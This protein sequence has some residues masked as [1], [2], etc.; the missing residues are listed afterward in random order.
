M[1]FRDPEGVSVRDSEAIVRAPGMVS[2]P[3]T[4][5]VFGV[6][7]A[8]KPPQTTP[9]PVESP[10]RRW[11]KKCHQLC[12]VCYSPCCFGNQVHGLHA[13]ERHWHRMQ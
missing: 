4:L 12:A 11:S 6:P 2:G 9:P 10:R 3:T 5:P 1:Q 7:P 8:S 13:C